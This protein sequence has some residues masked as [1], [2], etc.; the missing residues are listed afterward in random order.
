MF[1]APN[2]PPALI[3][4]TSLEPLQKLGPRFLYAGQFLHVSSF[5]SQALSPFGERFAF[6]WLVLAHHA[7][8]LTA[9]PMHHFLHSSWHNSHF[10]HHPSVYAHQ[11]PFAHM[12]LQFPK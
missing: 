10:L 1:F 8:F 11:K 12:H 5:S 7:R 6:V 9:H 3:F 2:N 4:V